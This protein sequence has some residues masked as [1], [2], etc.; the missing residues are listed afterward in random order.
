MLT[1]GQLDARLNNVASI[2]ILC[3]GLLGDVFI[4][5]PLIEALRRRFPRARIVVVVDPPALAVLQHH[6]DCDELIAFSR[7]KKP[8]LTYV[9]E[10]YKTLMKLRRRRFDLLINLYCGGSSARFSRV[11]NAGIRL[12][13]D[14]TRALR[15]A[16]NVLA[17]YPSFSGNWSKALGSMLLPLGIQDQDIRR[18]SSFYCTAQAQARARERL[19]DAPRP[20]VAINLGAGSAEKRWPVERFVELA[21]RIHA[22]HGHV[23]LVFTNPGAEHLAEDF[24]R[25]YRPQGRLI[26][27]PVVPLDEVGAL[28][29]ECDAIITGDTS[30]MHLAFALK[31]PTLVLFTF[32]RPEMVLPEDVTVASCFVESTS[33]A[34]YCGRPAGSVDIPVDL[35]LRQFD[36]LVTMKEKSQ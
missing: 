30:L 31:R 28:M 9:V 24:A 14:H 4:R 15:A 34:Q 33:G 21:R 22:R 36:Q 20:L 27:V 6:P 1:Q 17:P 12:S 2:V 29:S 5:V 26:V 11:I 18:G 25:H 19:A 13:F 23:P 8:R 7:V 3:W 10:T 35:A 32:T 16:N